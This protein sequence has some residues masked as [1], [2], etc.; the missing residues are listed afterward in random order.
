MPCLKITC[1]KPWKHAGCLS[2][3]PRKS[4]CLGPQVQVSLGHVAGREHWAGG[5]LSAMYL[6]DT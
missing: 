6:Q 3:P 5:V 4:V 2:Q 1:A